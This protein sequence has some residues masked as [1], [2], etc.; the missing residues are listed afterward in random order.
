VD[1]YTRECLSIDVSRRL[2]SDD[3]LERL[4]WL[5]ATRSVPELIH[6]DN[7]P[8]FTANAVRAWLNNVGV[9]TLY[10]EPGSPWENGYIKSFNGKLRDE[11][12][13][14]EIFY[15]LV[16]AK[17]LIERWRQEYNMVRPHN[18]LG[19]PP[20][21]PEVIA[22]FCPAAGYATWPEDSTPPAARQEET[23]RLT[24]KVVQCSG[25]GHVALMPARS[26]SR[27][28]LSG[29]STRDTS[30]IVICHRHSAKTAGY[31]DSSMGAG[32]AARANAGKQSSVA[33]AIVS[34]TE[35]R[36]TGGKLATVAQEV[37]V[38]DSGR[39]THGHS[40]KRRKC[41]WGTRQVTYVALIAAVI[42]NYPGPVAP[43]SPKLTSDVVTGIS[44]PDVD[45]LTEDMALVWG[46]A[47]EGSTATVT[48]DSSRTWM[49]ASSLRF[50][51]EGGFDTWVWA[52]VTRDAEWDLI[53]SGSKGL[54]FWAYA[55]NPNPGFQNLSPWIRLHTAAN[56]Y[57]ELHSKTEVLNSARDRWIHLN[58]PI[59]GDAGW[60][61][62]EVG[63]PNLANIN[64]I[65]FHADTWDSG[66]TLWIDGLAFDAEPGAPASP[67]YSVTPV[68]FIPDPAS[69]PS[70]FEPT[71]IQLDA[72]MAHIQMA[73]TEIRSW[74]SHALGLET[75]FNLQ[76]V[77]RI[78]AWGGLDDYEI[79]WVNPNSRYT[80]GITIGNTWG[81]VLSEVAARGFSAGS[82]EEPQAVVIFC[83]GA[84]G[85]AGG[86]QFHNTTGGGA[87]MLGDWALD[88]LADRVPPENWSWWTG[89]NRQK[90]ATAHEMGHTLGLPHPDT[91]NPVTDEQDYPYT[92]MG[93]WWQW[94]DY[95]EN[96]ADKTWPLT[97]LHGWGSNS[98]SNTVFDYNDQFLLAYRAQW[99]QNVPNCPA[100]VEDDQVVNLL[101]FVRFR[102][103]VANTKDE[104]LARDC[105]CLD[106]DHDNDLD[107]QD[108]G[109]LQ[110]AFTGNR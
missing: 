63:S 92:L 11:L 71:A 78:E 30:R 5:S 105:E 34:R 3:V 81:L 9:R 98:G 56:D 35:R 19:Y 46:A 57:I 12:L 50:D 95:P 108:F 82:P 49:G 23:V 93:D 79:S 67:P 43:E 74:Y 54:S 41:S 64:W 77:V 76:P 107:L 80:D 17:V 42:L 45:A 69:F 102:V 20:P 1:E 60:T 29:I 104:W 87:C 96:P 53:A 25:A 99:F 65:E 110:I 88:S 47:A 39:R 10:I 15:T 44:V 97:G 24:W 109:A 21:A 89:D 31:G 91:P 6:S 70:G 4:S 75:S 51:T 94:P 22:V 72:D 61:T 68:L 73:M 40:M 36:G 37:F 8:E 106:F 16:K 58:V 52:P 38:D 84:G 26:L 62:E 13:N 101:D 33:L 27:V 55:D 14:G 7:G 32:R 2:R 28:F 83:K 66:F 100:S 90:G 59:D 48:D 85:F 18:A 86:A 103:C